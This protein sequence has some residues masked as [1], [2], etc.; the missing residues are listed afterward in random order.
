VREAVR[1]TIEWYALRHRGADAATLRREMV[2]Q[3]RAYAGGV[4]QPG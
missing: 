4:E 3:W 2:A 1:H